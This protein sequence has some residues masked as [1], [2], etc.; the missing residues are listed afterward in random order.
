MIWLSNNLAGK[1][2]RFSATSFTLLCALAGDLAFLF[3]LGNF[4]FRRGCCEKETSWMALRIDMALPQY[5]RQLTHKKPNK[6]S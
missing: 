6:Q 5:N 3:T 2:V 1:I 4:P